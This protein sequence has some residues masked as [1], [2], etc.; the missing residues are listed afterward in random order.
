MTD[1]QLRDSR[2]RPFRRLPAALLLILMLSCAMGSGCIN[3]LVML[4]KVMLGDPVQTSAFEMATRINLKKSERPVLVHCSSPD[5]LT[6]EF[7][8]IAGDVQ[9][10]LVRKMRRRGVNVLHTD[11]AGRILDD[12][13]GKFDAQFLAH[14]CKDTDFIMHIEINEFSYMEPA[15]HTLYRG[16]AAGKIVGY[17]VRGQDSSQPHAVEIFAQRFQVQYPS[18][19]PVPVDQ[20]PKNVFIRRFVDNIAANLGA[21]FYNVAQSELY[22]D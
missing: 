11:T 12:R 18:S 5:F 4:S 15:S 6:I 14:E 10:E 19:H 13:G 17:E 20:T 8:T 21:S 1:H 3:S 7:G 16:K 2:C 9:Q 22:S